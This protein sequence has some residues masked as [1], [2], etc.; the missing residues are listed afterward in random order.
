MFS[1]HIQQ[2]TTKLEEEAAKLGL[3]INSDKTKS[4]RVNARNPDPV[5]VGGAPVEDVGTRT[6]STE[7]DVEARIRKARNFYHDLREIWNSRQIS[8][9]LNCEVCDVIWIRDLAYGRF[10]LIVTTN[11]HQQI[12][13]ENH[14]SFLATVGD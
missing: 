5:T 14:G 11:L 7:E 12:S 9:K 8:I 2:K 10:H 6:G 3:I 1:R 13:K 4:M